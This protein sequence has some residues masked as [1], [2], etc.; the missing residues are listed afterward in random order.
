MGN[1]IKSIL[2][3]QLPDDSSGKEP[4]KQPPIEQVD[5]LADKL[6]LAYKNP[7]YRR[8]YCGVINKFG[9]SKV[10]EWHRRSLE[11]KLPGRLFT[12]YVI[13]AGGYRRETD[14]AS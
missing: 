4:I 5:E 3:S 12:V 6:V 13:Q 10:L 9:V 8:W 2:Y 11:G 7:D 1:D 14:N